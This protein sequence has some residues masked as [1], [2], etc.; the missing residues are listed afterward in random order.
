[1]LVEPGEFV[2]E[3]TMDSGWRRTVG[4]TW[5]ALHPAAPPET[6]LAMEMDRKID[7]GGLTSC[8]PSG[9]KSMVSSWEYTCPALSVRIRDE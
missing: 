4:S 2:M 1:M 5:G 6:T 9:S 8:G 3:S 7:T